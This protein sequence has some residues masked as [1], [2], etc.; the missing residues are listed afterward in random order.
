MSKHTR[1]MADRSGK[2]QRQLPTDEELPND[3]SSRPGTEQ[4]STTK[5]RRI[6][7]ACSACRLRKSRVRGI[8]DHQAHSTPAEVATVQWRASSVSY[9]RTDGL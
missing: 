3:E 4:A 7:L 9:V 8:A 1:D 6:A 2:Q 5:R